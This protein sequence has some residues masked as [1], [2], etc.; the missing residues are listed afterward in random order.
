MKELGENG[1][2][3]LDGPDAPDQLHLQEGDM[4]D[5]IRIIEKFLVCWLPEMA[6]GSLQKM[7]AE[8]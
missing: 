6:R 7:R 8:F 2:E 3:G 1:D 4:L 5:K